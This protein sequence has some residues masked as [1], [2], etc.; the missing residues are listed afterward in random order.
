MYIVKRVDKRDR[1]G[2]DISFFFNNLSLTSCQKL[3]IVL[4][5]KMF[6]KLSINVL[7]LNIATWNHL[8]KI[9]KGAY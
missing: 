1:Q 4:R 5:I 9:K 3:G 2:R 8:K 6:Q 7:E